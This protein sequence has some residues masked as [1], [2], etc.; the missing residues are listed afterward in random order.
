LSS[1]GRSLDESLGIDNATREKGKRKQ[2]GSCA[3]GQLY[4]IARSHLV[5]FPCEFPLAGATI[6]LSPVVLD[7]LSSCSHVEKGGLAL[8]YAV[9][10]S[11]TFPFHCYLSTPT[12]D[13]ATSRSSSTCSTYEDPERRDGT[14]CNAV[15][16][17]V[18]HILPRQ[19]ASLNG[20]H[21]RTSS[22]S[23]WLENISGGPSF[24]RAG[25][26]EKLGRARLK[27]HRLVARGWVVEHRWHDGSWNMRSSK[28]IVC[29]TQSTALP[30]MT[31]RC[32]SH[33][34]RFFVDSSSVFALVSYLPSLALPLKPSLHDGTRLQPPLR[35]Q[36]RL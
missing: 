1:E 10:S 11:S 29:M 34:P 20:E 18:P 22:Q 24:G 32:S 13:V 21:I 2:L 15:H 5:N 25:T 31:F 28:I 8:A 6:L 9:E 19:P 36:T 7:A 12:W 27:G 14:N 26:S 30:I 4:I 17:L 3:Y 16:V 23:A 33:R 35:P